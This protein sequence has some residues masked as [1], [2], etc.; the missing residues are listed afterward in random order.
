MVMET[1]VEVAMVTAMMG[2]GVKGPCHGADN[3]RG[4]HGHGGGDCHGHVS[5]DECI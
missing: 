1:V 4:G 2:V 5:D 3:D